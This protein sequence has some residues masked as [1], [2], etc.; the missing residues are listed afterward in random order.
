MNPNETSINCVV[1]GGGGHAKVLIEALKTIPDLTIHCI[2]DVDPQR[3]QR[4]VL[5]VPIR[6]GDDLLPRLIREE[7]VTACVIGLGSVGSAAQRK[8][9]FLHSLAHGLEPLQVLY[10]TAIISKHALLGRGVQ[11]LAKAVINAEASI[12]DNVLVNS[13]AIV[14]HDCWIGDH[15]HIATGAIVC[16]GA[17]IEAEAHIGAGAVIRENITIGQGA[18]IGAGAVAVKDVPAYSTMIGV[19]AHPMPRPSE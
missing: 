10:T 11:V 5:G 9:L 4:S 14:E 18:I 8:R 1:L 3:W 15:T 19:P 2:L 12:G 16:S 13:G 17:R 7:G 6:G